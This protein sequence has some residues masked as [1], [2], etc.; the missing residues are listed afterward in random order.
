MPESSESQTERHVD[1]GLPLGSYSDEVLCECPNCGGPAR[2]RASVH[3]SVPISTRE[4]RAQCL[5]CSFSRE[6]ADG[7]WRGPILGYRKQPCPNCGYRWLVVEVFRERP[8]SRLKKAEKVCCPLCRE[9]SELQLEWL[10]EENTNRP[11]DPYFGLPLWLQSNCC[12]K[13]LWAYNRRHL[14]AIRSYIAAVRRERGGASGKWS[15]VARLPA[16]VKSAK[17]REAVLKCITRLEAKCDEA[18]LFE[19]R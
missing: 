6:L 5:R 16:W 4:A 18:G 17:N 13:V 8:D 19:N 10:R 9:M 12:C 15:M 14:N 2:V 3:W 7:K 1:P 11:I